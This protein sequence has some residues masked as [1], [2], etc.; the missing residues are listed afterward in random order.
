MHVK[1]GS[2]ASSIDDIK[3]TNETTD[4]KSNNTLLVFTSISQLQN[5]DATSD[6]C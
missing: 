2:L 5:L 6:V 3:Q 1:Y 4:K